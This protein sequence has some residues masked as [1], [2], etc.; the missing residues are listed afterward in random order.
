V[1]FLPKTFPI[2]ALPY[3]ID[4]KFDVALALCSAALTS[5]TRPIARQ[6]AQLLPQELFN[7]QGF[8]HWPRIIEKALNSVTGP[9]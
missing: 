3:I 5:G 4:Q 8:P 1:H 6:S 9:I 7:A 2:E